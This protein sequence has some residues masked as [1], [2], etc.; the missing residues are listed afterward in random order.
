[1]MR[2]WKGFSIMNRNTPRPCLMIPA[3]TLFQAIH[4]ARAVNTQR[5]TSDRLIEVQR[6]IYHLEN[7]YFSLT[8]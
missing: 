4:C 1:M 7:S 2:G 3:S 5:A 8:L 6:S